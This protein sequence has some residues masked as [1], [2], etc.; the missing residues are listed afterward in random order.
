MNLTIPEVINSECQ[1]YPE[2][3]VNIGGFA[4]FML[5]ASIIGFYMMIR[6]YEELNDY[7]VI[8]IL[9]LNIGSWL[10]LCL[11]LLLFA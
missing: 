4:L 9:A 2:I 10:C 11:A 3:L 1:T 8:F 7:V 6:K 5:I